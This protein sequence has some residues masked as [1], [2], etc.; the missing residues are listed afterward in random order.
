MLMHRTDDYT[1]FTDERSKG[2][3]IFII[4]CHGTGSDGRRT[5]IGVISVCICCGLSTGVTIHTGSQVCQSV[6]NVC[7]TGIRWVG[8]IRRIA[9]VKCVVSVANN[10]CCARDKKTILTKSFPIP[11]S[12]SSPVVRKKS[13]LASRITW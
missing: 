7:W 11:F 2:H 1:L 13:S 4:S 10:V 5:D 8:R 6:K 9:I 3:A 12:F